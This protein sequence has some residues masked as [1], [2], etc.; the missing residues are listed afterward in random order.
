M[1][2]K[3]LGSAP[4]SPKDPF[5]GL[6]CKAVEV[7]GYEK[8]SKSSAKLA[9]FMRHVALSRRTEGDPLSKASADQVKNSLGILLAYVESF[10]DEEVSQKAQLSD[11]QLAGE[12]AHAVSGK[13]VN[14]SKKSPR[15]T[16]KKKEAPKNDSTGNDGPKADP[17]A[18]SERSSDRAQEESEPLNAFDLSDTGFDQLTQDQKTYF[19]KKMTE[20]INSNKFTFEQLN[21]KDALRAAVLRAKQDVPRALHD[22]APTP[23]SPAS[24]RPSPKA[25]DSAPSP[26]ANDSATNTKNLLLALGIGG[27]AIAGAA[28]VGAGV[29]AYKGAYQGVMNA[30]TPAVASAQGVT[31]FD[32]PS[33]V[34]GDKIHLGGGFMQIDRQNDGTLVIRSENGNVINRITF[35]NSQGESV[36]RK[37]QIASLGDTFRFGT[38]RFPGSFEINIE[39]Q[40]PWGEIKETGFV[41]VR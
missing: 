13:S 3:Q 34:S 23:H 39:Y 7:N 41:E 30:P 6:A 16:K 19:I 15:K 4:E 20:V 8:L 5:E 36:V 27:V 10:S 26:K 2:E 31:T 9:L 38:D 11:D 25:E 24:S 29:S 14:A 1:T 22:P 17:K 40:T 18:K 28:A 33:P 21:N 37:E 12:A 32:M 35:K